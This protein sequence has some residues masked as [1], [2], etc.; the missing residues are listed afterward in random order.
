M[1]ISTFPFSLQWFPQKRI[2]LRNTCCSICSNIV[3]DRNIGNISPKYC[4]L[5]NVQTF[6][7]VHKVLVISQNRAQIKGSSHQK[8]NFAKLN[9]PPYQQSTDPTVADSHMW[10]YIPPS[11]HSLPTLAPHYQWRAQNNISHL[12][13]G[14][15]VWFT[16]ESSYLHQPPA[17][18][19]A[20]CMWMSSSCK[21]CLFIINETWRH[22]QCSGQ[23][24]ERIR[25]A[26]QH[27]AA[28]TDT[29]GGL[30]PPKNKNSGWWLS[31]NLDNF[32]IFNLP[33]VH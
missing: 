5:E 2:V 18:N 15:L 10:K 1:C 17:S 8:E 27:Y 25:D 9:C 12:L 14:H 21:I 22:L 32:A 4:R 6:L 11:S 3:L 7:H 31:Q 29:V 16:W 24:M 13:L 19:L 20:T 28:D 33:G 23:P 30:P 26:G